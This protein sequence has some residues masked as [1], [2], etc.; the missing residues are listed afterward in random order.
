MEIKNIDGEIILRIDNDIIK[1][2]VEEAVKSCADLRGANLRGADLIGANLYGAD[3]IGANLYGAN[4]GGANLIG[5]NLIDANLRDA[6]LYGANLYGANLRDAKNIPL[7][8]VACPSDGE[9][10]GWKNV[11]GKLIQLRIPEHAKRS[12]ATTEKCR[13]DMALVVSITD[14][15]TGD[16]IT[17]IVNHNYTDTTYRVG[18]TVYPDSYDEDRWIECSHGIHFFIDK[19]S[20][21]NY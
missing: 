18:E 5:A 4:L 21:I 14:I 16:E 15:E 7:V 1:D 19:E 9:F 17:E 20:A 11:D 13:C 12:S 8:P 6:N 10:T 2:A 3:L